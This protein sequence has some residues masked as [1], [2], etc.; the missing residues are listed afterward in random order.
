MTIIS[1]KHNRLSDLT[2]DN[3][4]EGCQ[5]G[6]QAAADTSDYLAECPSDLPF[7]LGAMQ[8]LVEVGSYT[9]VEIGFFTE[10]LERGS[11]VG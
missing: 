11:S 6:R 8:S 9:A 1:I 5:I 4:M 2:F 3:Y 10:L 7:V